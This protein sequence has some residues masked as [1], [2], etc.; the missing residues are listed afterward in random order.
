MQDVAFLDLDHS[1]SSGGDDHSAETKVSSLGLYAVHTVVCELI[2]MAD[3][4][5]ECILKLYIDR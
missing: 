5:E 2:N 1:A 4:R 3:F